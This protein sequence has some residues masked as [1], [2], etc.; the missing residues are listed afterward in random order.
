MASN[1]SSVLMKSVNFTR[2]CVFESQCLTK[3]RMY[4]RPLPTSQ[5]ITSHLRKHLLNY[6][7]SRNLTRVRA[8]T[9]IHIQA[10]RDP[11]NLGVCLSVCTMYQDRTLILLLSH[12]F[13]NAMINITS[14]NEVHESFLK[15]HTQGYSPLQHH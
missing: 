12:N 9:H 15:K 3:Y 8:R 1:C 10:P 2:S 13:S 14:L 6:S 4:R 5:S 11:L 7:H